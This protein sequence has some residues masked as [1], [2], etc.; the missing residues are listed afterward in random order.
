MQ[1][2]GSAAQSVTRIPVS[3]TFRV[4]ESVPSI[5]SSRRRIST[6]PAATESV[7]VTVSGTGASATAAV[8][9]DATTCP[10]SGGA[11]VCSLPIDAP[12]GND[13]AHRTTSRSA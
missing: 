10:P 3:L 12:I 11:Y 7:Q 6:I 2:H 1:A 5:S 4:P 13:T 8:N 9:V